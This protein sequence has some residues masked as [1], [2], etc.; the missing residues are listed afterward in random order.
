M[1]V[2]LAALPSLGGYVSLVKVVFMLLFIVPWLM[3]L[4]WIHQDVARVRGSQTRWTLTVLG[5][6]GLGVLIW[7]LVPAYFIGMVIYLVIVA[8]VLAGYVVWRD[9]RVGPGDK[10]I[11]VIRARGFMLRG[12]G[13]K[14]EVVQRVKIYDDRNVLIQPPDPETA[15][16]P[17][18]ETYN[19]VQDFL[20]SML[21][22][23]ASEADISP[24]SQQSAVV[25]FIVDG[26]LSVQP[27]MSLIQS[28]ILIQAL[29]PISG[30][31]PEERRRPQE[32]T[33]SIDFAGK[34][35][36]IG[37]TTTGSTGGQRMQF[38]AMH[39]AIR[40]KIDELGMTD[41]IAKSVRAMAQTKAGLVIVSGR[42]GSGVTSTLYSILRSMDAYTRR[43]VTIESKPA[44]DME[45]VTQT[46]YG[47]PKKLVK[48]LTAA[49]RRDPDVIMIDAC[50]DAETAGLIAQASA[51]KLVILGLGAVD[52]FMGL[53]LWIKACG[54]GSSAGMANLRGVLCQALI[55]NLC[56]AC[57]QPYR[58]DPKLLAKAN[59]TSSQIER[60]Y[61]APEGQQLDEEGEPVIC[62]SCQG[63]GYI[64]RTGVFELLEMTDEIRQLVTEQAQLAQIKSACRKNNMQYLQE[65][66]IG[67]VIDGLTSIQEVIR[68][69][70]QGKK[71]K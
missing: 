18:C 47:D 33:L 22:H 36:E 61:K 2:I 55:R 25:R 27:S 5:G 11:S 7:L 68:V 42:V 60:F 49:L 10:L 51:S 32:G 53:A 24:G 23:R 17:E 12:K 52:T 8:A 6:G 45:N 15:S 34:Q 50:P 62:P 21:T 9:A 46:A 1:T 38:R 16:V 41:K 14:I 31:D 43:L 29:K 30:L 65:N 67:K 66:A 57:R 63:T 19:S 69:T 37:V 20:V 4:P 64:G 54:E 58:P 48:A 39:E 40:T 3:T 44:A 35:I 26:V 71:K 13:V 70:Q 59:L 28:D 56:P